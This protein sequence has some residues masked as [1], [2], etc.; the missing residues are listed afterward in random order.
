MG[1]RGKMILEHDG[2]G[3]G[4]WLKWLRE[5]PRH[6]GLLE[7]RE[8]LA[9]AAGAAAPAPG[10]APCAH[11]S[12]PP[13]RRRKTKSRIPFLI[14]GML[15][16]ATIA[17]GG[18][19]LIRWN[20]ARL[21][22]IADSVIDGGE[23]PP[24]KPRSPSRPPPTTSLLFLPKIRHRDL[25]PRFR[26]TR[27]RPGRRSRSAGGHGVQRLHAE[28]RAGEGRHG[29][30]RKAEIDSRKGVFQMEDASLLLEMSGRPVSWKA[31]SEG[32]EILEREREDVLSVV[33]RR[34][35]RGQG[36]RRHRSLESPRRHRGSRAQGTH[37]EKTADQGHREERPVRQQLG[38]GGDV[39]QAERD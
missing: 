3:L 30:K 5:A 4:G 36:P 2:E 27:P 39:R 29:R 22:V 38:A 12:A 23:E 26:P 10:E 25:L 28:R 32:R 15:S 33:F 13:P 37:R 6:T 8:K 1:W 19:G 16:L 7:A 35:G 31:R 21:K 9:A 14:G 17:F 11:R 24:K 20:N 18:W 34:R